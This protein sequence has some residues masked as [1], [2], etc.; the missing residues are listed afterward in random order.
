MAKKKSEMFR[1]ILQ[2]FKVSIF[3]SKCLAC[4]LFFHQKQDKPAGKTPFD[5]IVHDPIETVFYRVMTPFLCSS[6]LSDFS[7]VQSPFCTQCGRM[8]ESKSGD[9]HQCGDCIQNKTLCSG[10]RAAGIYRGALKSNI[11]ALKYNNKVHLARP[12]GRLL[13]SSFMKYYNASTIDYIMPVP[14][15]ISRLKQ[16]GFNQAAMLI[17]QWPVLFSQ[18]EH[19][20]IPIDC[21]NLARKRKTLSQ[22]G[23]GKKKRK[24]N[25]K[26]AFAVKDKSNISGKH[27]L[28]IDDVYT[29]GSTC[30]E[31]AKTLISKGAK[32]VSVLALARA[33]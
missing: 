31:C 26:D 9:N 29:T 24:Q 20:C 25:V 6:C 22:T 19:R 4:G 11:H 16:R 30:D 28:L 33:D 15:H 8:F 10:I 17:R 21:K 3:P 14:L 18:T 1:R 12:L 13:F 2:T 5:Q 7:P 32:T 23:L 27:V